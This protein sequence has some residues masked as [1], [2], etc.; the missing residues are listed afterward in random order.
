MGEPVEFVLCQSPGLTP[1]K[2]VICQSPGLT[3]VD[4]WTP[5]PVKISIAL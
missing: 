2:F 4:V 5:G 3:S 1:V